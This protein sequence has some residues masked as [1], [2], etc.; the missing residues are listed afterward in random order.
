[1]IDGDDFDRIFDRTE[2]KPH[3]SNSTHMTGEVI[4]KRITLD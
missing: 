1:L 3:Q 2:G 4:V